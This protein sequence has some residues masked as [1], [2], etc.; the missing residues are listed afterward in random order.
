MQMHFGLKTN[1]LL[2]KETKNGADHGR[3]KVGMSSLR[4]EA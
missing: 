2:I 4:T 3:K 1:T